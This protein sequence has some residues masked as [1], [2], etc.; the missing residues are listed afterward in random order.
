M[1][2]LMKIPTKNKNHIE[3]HHPK[4]GTPGVGLSMVWFFYSLFSGIF[5][6][7]FLI[8]SFSFLWTY[9]RSPRRKRDVIDESKERI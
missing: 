9:H 1:E 5:H 6:D 2:S 4:D 7:S 8:G 3:K